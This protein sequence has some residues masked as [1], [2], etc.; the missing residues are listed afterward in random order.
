MWWSLRFWF[1]LFRTIW[2]RI[3]SNLYVGQ[4][5]VYCWSKVRKLLFIHLVKWC[6][7]VNYFWLNL[8]KIL[9]GNFIF[10]ISASS[11]LFSWFLIFFVTISKTFGTCFNQKKNRN[12]A[13]SKL[14]VNKSSKL[15]NNGSRIHVISVR[16]LPV[17]I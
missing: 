9:G 4:S 10:V 13:V 6:I 15:S 14:R 17:I 12:I 2:I 16:T 11:G 8:L 3:Y 5:S 7:R 1:V